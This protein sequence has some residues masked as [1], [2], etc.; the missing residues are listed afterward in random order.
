MKAIGAEIVRKLM[1]TNTVAKQPIV[2]QM[3][4]KFQNDYDTMCDIYS[5][6]IHR[7]WKD[8]IVRKI[9]SSSLGVVRATYPWKHSHK[10]Q[11][12]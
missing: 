8:E 9:V 5:L 12:H 10:T 11:D 7:I 2:N 6:G 4:D 1:H 3:F